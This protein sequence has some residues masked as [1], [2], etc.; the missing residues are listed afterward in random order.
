[1]RPHRTIRTPR[2]RL[3]WVPAFQEKLG[4]GDPVGAVDLLAARAPKRKG[5]PGVVGAHTEAA[6][7]LL[8][9]AAN[10][11]LV[12]RDWAL[13]LIVQKGP[14]H[15]ALGASL[16]HGMWAT[17]PKDVEREVAAL[18][19]E[20]EWVTREQA[21]AL[22]GSV[23]DAHFVKFLPRAREWARGPS[24]RLRRA[25]VLAAKHAARGR[26][27]SRAEP[28]LDLV[29]A[30]LRDPDEYVRKN[31]GAFAI[32]DGLLRAYPEATLARLAHWSKD[33]DENV[34]WNVAM[35]FTAAEAAKH[36]E[37]ALAILAVLAADERKFVWRATAGALRNLARRKPA[38]VR[39]TLFAWRDDP[40][41]K[42]AAEL[43]I[44]LAPSV[45]V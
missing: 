24:S 23:L 27:L 5:Q 19:E 31:L 7:R 14:T 20:E 12:R 42:Q 8:Q 2:P 16:L 33:T 3:A 25:V 38:D 9:E 22:L 43:A 11:A 36:V 40:A 39:A 4:R 15:K 37:P 29:E 35:T 21:A 26:E 34:R 32:G 44:A 41:R 30:P 28:L 10:S 45:R 18:A 13:R 17:Y 6:A 1:M